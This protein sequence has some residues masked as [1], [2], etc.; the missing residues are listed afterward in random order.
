MKSIC[1]YCGSSDKI[2]PE[3]YEVARQMGST[4]ANRGIQLWYGAGS[5]GLMGALAEAVL[6]AGGEVIGVIPAMFNNFRVRLIFFSA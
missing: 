3:Y 5:T 1:V 4:I 6:A 2:Q